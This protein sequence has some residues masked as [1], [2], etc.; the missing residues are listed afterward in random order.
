MKMALKLR[1]SFV[2]FLL[3]TI[4]VSSILLAQTAPPCSLQGKVTDPSGA[5]IEQAQIV[6][7]GPGGEKHTVTDA[8]GKYKF[9]ALAP[10]KYIIRV[11]AKGFAVNEKT[12]FE[13][14]GAAV[15]DAQLAIASISEQITLTD[16]ADR[17]TVSVAPEQ[18][19]GAIVLKEKDLETLSDDPDELSQ[20]LQ[21]MAGP[22]AGPNGG[23]VFIDGF[24][25]NGQLPPKSSIREIR[26][27]SNPF[28]SEYDRPGFGRIEIFTKPGTDTFHGQAYFQFN[29]QDL[30]TRSPLLA[31]SNLP[32]YKQESYNINLSGPLKVRKASFSFNAEHRSITED[33]FIEA[34]TLDSNFNPVTVN[35]T[36]QTPQT[37]T[38]ITP[39]LD[40][41]LTDKNTLTVRYQYTNISLNDQGVGNFNLPSTTF[42][43]STTEDT[44]QATE[45]ATISANTVNETRF[46][47]RHA[48][49]ADSG[50]GT[51]YSLLVQDA[52]TSGGAT[53]G[54]SGDTTNSW[55]A[56]NMTTYNHR[57][58]TF[59][60]GFRARQSFDNNT[61]ISNFN[62]T[63]SFFGGQGP[64]L[65]VNN[66]A[67]AG[68]TE[69]LTALQVYQRT[70]LLQH[71]GFSPAQIRA[72][73]GGASLF[74]LGA[75]APMTSVNQLDL[76]FYGNDDWK[77]LSN[78]TLSY[79]LRYETQTNISD[80]GDFSP[81]IGIAWGIDGKGNKA[82][83]T[84]LRVGF[85]TFYDRISASTKLQT[86][87]YN[88]ITQQSYI[89]L[90]PDFYPNIPSLASLQ[91]GLQPQQLQFLAHDVIAPRNYQANVGIERQV[92]KYF[93]ISANYIL[94][95][96][97]H[98]L[99][100]RDIN[101][102]IDGIYP[103]GDHEAR[104][105]TESTGFSRTSQLVINPSISYK[106]ISLY[107]NYS[108]SYGKDDN[109]GQPA[110][111]FNLRAEWGPSSY[112]DIR[113]RGVF[114]VSLPLLFKVSI[115]PFIT[116]SSGS[117]YNIITGRNLYGDGVIS[118]RPALVSVSAANC[119]GTD[120]LYEPSFGCF[121]LNPAPGTP[122]I[123]RNFGR[124]P[125]SVNVNLRISR[126][127]A[128]GSKEKS[129]GSASDAR[130]PG[131]MGGP[132]GGGFPGM[133]GGFPRGGGGRG[134]GPMGGG[135]SAGSGKYNIT[136]SIQATNALNHPNFGPP[137]GD[138]A[139]SYFGEHLSLG[140]FGAGGV[141]NIFDRR[142][143]FQLRFAF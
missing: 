85:G 65:D 78:L 121:N 132:R 125:A 4:V 105:F 14:N 1:L 137:N 91:S 100:S 43:Q 68:T 139:S 54:N 129:A 80:H 44:L 133:G 67:I 51:A 25:G 115:N 81:R 29:N 53:V 64:L 76:G 39:R 56:S 22:G 77:A 118:A 69:Q 72:L 119:S 103:F 71:A 46:Q 97:V 95:R 111:P 16:E 45:T 18:N 15:F 135:G 136:L 110:D 11:T 23:Q 34:T 7:K 112:G 17:V 10:G 84:V 50:A 128:I 114:G 101:A 2:V 88:G 109:E 93:R 87:R 12:S 52:F 8:D 73:G 138:L 94:S 140:G 123:N 38:T 49:S 131:G 61:S 83:K 98:L 36:M 134:G 89:I 57:K 70:L 63:F 66:Q 5:V 24:S 107:G 42:N 3:S 113:H 9:S 126:T 62:G 104:F 37:R 31:Q 143:S 117:P 74:T 47:F 99:R 13:I 35:Q 120:L 92:N 130:P 86:L 106:N 33:A 27:N 28:S 19:A 41:T 96:G 20:E 127:W 48:S 59:K 58:H 75:G 82:A 116:A 26:I 21:A 60:W 32:P 141:S 122:T 30:N 90:N 102:P 108:L 40:F 124:G 142:V 6:I 79:G 55:E